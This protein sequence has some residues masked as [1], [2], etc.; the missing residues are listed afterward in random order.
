MLLHVKIFVTKV[1]QFEITLLKSP[2]INLLNELNIIIII[3]KVCSSCFITE[4]LR[5]FNQMFLLSPC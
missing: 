2:S 3:T 4:K 5:I 1:T